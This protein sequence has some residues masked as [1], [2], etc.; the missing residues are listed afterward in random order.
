MHSFTHPIG[1]IPEAVAYAWPGAYPIIYVVDDGDVLCADCVNDPTNPTHFGGDADGWR[2]EGCQLHMEGAPE[3]CAHC[4]REIPSAYGVDLVGSAS[5]VSAFVNESWQGVYATYF[6]RHTL[7]GE[8][9][10]TLIHSPDGRKVYTLVA[11]NGRM[12]E[13]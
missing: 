2:V 8:L 1:P 4:N 9:W 11:S 12:I 6:C 5:T 10:A 7:G 13:V 3:H